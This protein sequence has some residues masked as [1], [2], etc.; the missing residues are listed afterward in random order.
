MSVSSH[1]AA[2]LQ[3]HTQGLELFPFIKYTHFLPEYAQTGEN[4]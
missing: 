2:R 1:L 4:L 3:G